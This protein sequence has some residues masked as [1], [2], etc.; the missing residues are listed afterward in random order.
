MK[1]T[2]L[3]SGSTGNCYV[4]EGRTS[5]LILECGVAPERVFQE[6][7]VQ[8]SNVSGCLISHEHGDHAAFADKFARYGMH[9]Y[10]SLGTIRA[11]GLWATP[12]V[13]SLQALRP[14][15]VGEFVVTPF[16]VCHDAAEPLGFLIT[17]PELGKLLFATDTMRMDCG[18]RGLNHLMIEAN[19]SEDILDRRVGAGQEDVARAARIKGTHLSIERACEYARKVDGPALENVVLMHLSYRNS[20]EARFRGMMATSTRLAEVYVASPGLT[21]EL[22]KSR[23]L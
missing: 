19:W 13:L 14:A 5:A 18:F 15:V 20:D 11:A 10:S 8:P 7:H 16:D 17:H 23:V 3:A 2:V 12:R 9:V 21:V 1:L 4:L 22:S 6:T